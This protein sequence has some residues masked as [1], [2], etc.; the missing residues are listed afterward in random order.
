MSLGSM[1]PDLMHSVPV[2]QE[3]VQD[4]RPEPAPNITSTHM[5]PINESQNLKDLC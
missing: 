4:T 3:C 1:T 5:E 2:V